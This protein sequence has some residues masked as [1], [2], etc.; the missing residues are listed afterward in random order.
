MK[1]IH[2]YYI[3]PDFPGWES[4]A[5]PTIEEIKKSGLWDQAT[6]ITF[7]LHY[8]LDNFKNFISEF[9]DPKVRFYNNAYAIPSTGEM[10][11]NFLIQQDALA[12]TEP[13]YILRGHVKGI[14]WLGKSEW[15]GV[16]AWAD[17]MVKYNVAQWTNALEKLEQ[18]YDC[19]G[20]HW[21]GEPWPCGHFA[22]TWW[23]ANSEYIKKCLPAQQP[24]TV[25]YNTQFYPEINGSSRRHDAEVWIGTGF[26]KAYDLYTSSSNFRSENPNFWDENYKKFC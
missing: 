5:Y 16:K 9:N 1:P 18:G 14:T 8:N 19:A 17:D 7:V 12:S 23:W 3:I 10:Y 13:Y 20:I 24:H 6:Q 11:G 25:G 22:G 15:L 4:L 26:P 21:R 2:I